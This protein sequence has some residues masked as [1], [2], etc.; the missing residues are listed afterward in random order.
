MK[1]EGVIKER[2]RKEKRGRVKEGKRE[3]GNR[4][5]KRRLKGGK[6]VDASKRNEK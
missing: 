5:N 2:K 3:R 6:K 4:G 1:Y